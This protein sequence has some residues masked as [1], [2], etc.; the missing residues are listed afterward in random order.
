MVNEQTYDANNPEFIEAIQKADVKIATKVFGEHPGDVVATIKTTVDA[1]K[2][3]EE[4]FV[5]L[6]KELNEP[7]TGCISFRAKRLVGM[8]KYI[9]IDFVD[10]ADHRLEQYEKSLLKS[11]AIEPSEVQ[12]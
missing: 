10:F 9:A 1:L 11:G 2:W 6:E 4:V 7:G 12:S 3:I 5:S 8:G